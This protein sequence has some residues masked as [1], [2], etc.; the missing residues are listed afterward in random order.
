MTTSLADRIKGFGVARAGR[1]AAAALLVPAAW[2]FGAEAAGYDWP[3]WRGPLRNGHTAEAAAAWRGTNGLPVL[4]KASVGKGFSSFAVAEGRAYTLGNAEGHDSVFCFASATG[5]VLWRHRYPCDPQPLAYEGGPSATPAVAGG[6]VYTFSK[7]GHLFCLDAR[8]GRV[9]WSKKFDPWP[10]REGDWKNTWRY[11]GSPLVAG[12]RLIVCVGEAG[13]ALNASDGAVL[14]QSP[15]GHPGYSSPVPFRAGAAEALAFFS[16]RSVIAVEAETGR[17]LWEVPW[18]T[19]WDMNAADPLIHEGK[20]FVSSG[21]GV[22]CALYDLAATPPRELWRN[23]HLKTPMNGAVLWQGRI[24]GFN[25]ADLACVDWETGAERW[26]TREVRRGSLV[27]A[28]GQL[29]LLCEKGRLVV[30]EAAGDAYRPLAQ[31][32]VLSG[33]CWS[34]P[35]LAHGLIYAR[36]ANGDVVCMDARAASR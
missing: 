7:E 15:A 30:A 10:H 34:S 13:L 32:Q 35:V 12:E 9:V 19:E 22:G 11:A 27:V 3:C 6:R 18:R 29:L 20:M 14:W 4:W 2:A 36:N 1:G 17:R 26:A 33:R 24:F 5:E 21:N 28:G 23:K 31:A 16:G 25:D 8:D